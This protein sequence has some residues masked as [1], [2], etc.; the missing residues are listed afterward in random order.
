MRGKYVVLGLVLVLCFGLCQCLHSDGT[1]VTP[2][3]AEQLN[4]RAA[5]FC[6]SVNWNKAATLSAMQSVQQS[7]TP[8]ESIVDPSNKW[9][10]AEVHIGPT[11]LEV[12]NTTGLIRFAMNEDVLKSM[13]G[14]SVEI[15]ASSA[16]QSASTYLAA[17]G[18][19]LDD[20]V[21]YSS[22]LVR[23]GSDVSFAE[24]AVEY[25]RVYNGYQFYPDDFIRVTLNPADGT[26]ASFGYNFHSPL[27]ES[28]KVDVEHDAAVQKAT[29]YLAGLG[30]NASSLVSADLQI[31]QPNDYW[32]YLDAGARPAT[33]TTSRL[34]WVVKFS[35]PWTRTEV[36]VDAA[37]GEVVGGVKS[38]STTKTVI[39][40]PNFQDVK[41]LQFNT[42]T[43]KSVHTVNMKST[44][45][46]G[47]SIL[48]Q[49]K[50]MQRVDPKQCRYSTMIEL[51]S[52]TRKY[53]LGYSAKD[54]ILMLLNKEYGDKVIKAHAA[55]K[56]SKIIESAIAKSIAM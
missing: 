4:D 16:N 5:Q 46:L 50:T 48:Q 21:L 34:A 39:T 40:F 52:S 8:E 13:V 44:D 17:A 15:S 49:I 37:T 28:T 6:Q 11:V 14:G 18:I 12:N 47:K 22:K 20:A 10:C 31:V 51:R 9:N 27:P 25:R 35:V 42:K 24:W 7:D 54:H 32:E 3:T 30:L 53:T 26:L 23:Y 55:W 45:P 33:P 41:T 38:L 19:S 29:Q 1:G 2:L 56:T 36:W 43:G